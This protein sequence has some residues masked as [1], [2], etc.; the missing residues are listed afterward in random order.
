MPEV[1][2]REFGEDY[3]YKVTDVDGDEYREVAR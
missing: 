3:G 2:M 1:A